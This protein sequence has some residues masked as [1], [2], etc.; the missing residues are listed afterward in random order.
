MKRKIE[1]KRR[2]RAFYLS[3]GFA[4]LL[5]GVLVG[6][7]I[8]EAA[9]LSTIPI[10]YSLGFGI[11]GGVLLGNQ[12]C[13]SMEDLEAERDRRRTYRMKEVRR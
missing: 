3:H 1:S 10:G 4:G 9:L 12:Y 5:I 6:L 2:R 13:W 11:V 7:V 8:T